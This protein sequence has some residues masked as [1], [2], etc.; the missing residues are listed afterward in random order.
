MRIKRV[1]LSGRGSGL[2]LLQSGAAC[3]VSQDENI[4]ETVLCFDA[5]G[6]RLWH[7]DLADLVEY[8]SIMVLGWEI[9][10][11]ADPCPWLGSSLKGT[12]QEIGPNARRTVSLADFLRPG[13]ALASF[14]RL[15]DGF[16]VSTCQSQLDQWREPR[17]MRLDDVA[18]PRWATS[19]PIDS[20]DSKHP[21]TLYFVTEPLVVA[22]GFL[23]AGFSAVR[24]GFGHWY[25][26]NAETGEMLWYT[27]I[28]SVHHA[29]TVGAGRFLVGSP[30]HKATQL[31]NARKGFEREWATYGDWVVRESGEVRLVEEKNWKPSRMHVGVLQQDGGMRKGPLL[32][33]FGT[34]YP[35]VTSSG[36]MV[37]WRNG[38][39]SVVDESLE[40][41]VLHRETTLSE[42]ASDRMLREPGGKLVFTVQDELWLVDA[43]IGEMAKSPWPCGGGNPG[44]NPVWLA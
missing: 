39:L 7:L 11:A 1:K 15:P 23:L 5:D 6:N 3:L 43:G 14:L 24:G 25:C 12:I 19:L 20:H 18:Q 10:A 13:E 31:Y 37:F 36:E 42:T 41:H 44:G 32:D 28:R 38:E 22:A 9:R 21:W 27:S 40:K 34:T 16:I 29:A 30:S 35:F 26:L 8:S 4:A 33:G 2:V 17:V